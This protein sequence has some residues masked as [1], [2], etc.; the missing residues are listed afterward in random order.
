MVFVLL[1]LRGKSILSLI[2]LIRSQKYFS[3]A[4]SYT[5]QP[6][7]ILWVVSFYKYKRKHF[8]KTF[9][10]FFFL[11]LHHSPSLLLGNKF[12]FFSVWSSFSWH[13]FHSFL[14]RESYWSTKIVRLF[15]TTIYFCI[16]IGSIG[17]FEYVFH[18]ILVL[19]FVVNICDNVIFLKFIIN[20]MHFS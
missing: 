14:L 15:V 6:F 11:F 12:I 2:G 10:L 4:T 3:N 19:S 17:Y 5:F 13:C 1:L 7:R 20:V 18:D 9:T 16:V 8:G